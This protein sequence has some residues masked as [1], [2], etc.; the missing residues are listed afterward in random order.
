MPR[1]GEDMGQWH[2]PSQVAL[3]I[4]KIQLDT[5]LKQLYEFEWDMGWTESST[6]DNWLRNTKDRIEKLTGRSL[7]SFINPYTIN[8][9]NVKRSLHGYGV[10][11]AKKYKKISEEERKKI[12]RELDKEDL[13]IINQAYEERIKEL[14][15]EISKQKK[16]KSKCITFYKIEEIYNDHNRRMY[17]E[18]ICIILGIS[19]RTLNDKLH[20][21][22]IFSERKIRS[23]AIASTPLLSAL[24]SDIYFSSNGVYGQRRVHEEI[25]RRGYH[26]SLGVVSSTMR[27]TKLYANEVKTTHKK[28]EDKNVEFNGN[29]LIT[30]ELI[31]SSKPGEVFSIDFSQIE[32]SCGKMWLHAARDIVTR[33]IEFLYLCDNQSAET[34]LSH[35]R[36]LPETTKIVNTDH[37]ASY[38]SYKVQ[39]YLSSRKIKQSTGGVGCSY[40]NRWIE[41]FW[42]R[43]KN[44]WFTKYPTRLIK[45][46]EVQLNM[47]NYVEFHNNKR[48][49]KIDGKWFTPTEYE[50]NLYNESGQFI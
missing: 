21:K 32:T 13:V 40:H 45:N 14:E 44:E 46:H 35:Y 30:D 49:T 8:Y 24:V 18:K 2:R 1:N 20:K 28:Y 43:I 6:Y 39:E 42:K 37:G 47:T 22:N 19:R 4:K 7:H 38:L 29:Y 11:M 15:E 50:K 48:L 31:K 5:P 23:N 3:I 41:D 27:R 36:Q 10:K 9:M 34:V 17:K 33:K 26:Y 16:I 12:L 25:K